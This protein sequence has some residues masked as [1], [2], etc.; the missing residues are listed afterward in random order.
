MTWIEDKSVEILWT[1]FSQFIEGL[2][3]IFIF[4]ISCDNELGFPGQASLF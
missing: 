2:L 3:E 1:L 4:V